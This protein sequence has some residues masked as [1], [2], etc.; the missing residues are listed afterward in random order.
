M[1]ILTMPGGAKELA[2]HFGISIYAHERE[3][4][5]LE[6]PELNL[7]GWVGRQDVY[8]ADCYLRDEQEIDLA[9][10][11]I[12]VL[13]T[14]GIRL[15]VAVISLVIRT[16]FLSGIRCLHSRLGARISKRAACLICCAA[17]RKN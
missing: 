17:L 13:Y 9:G 14:P 7:S 15:A 8:Q 3:K 1:G 12:R 5:T 10:F 4:E 16:R 2:A 11:H 6:N